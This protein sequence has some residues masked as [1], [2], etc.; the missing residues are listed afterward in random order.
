MSNNQNLRE[1]RRVPVSVAA[2]GELSLKGEGLD[3]RP[4]RKSSARSISF[5]NRSAVPLHGQL[6]YLRVIQIRTVRRVSIEDVAT[7]G[8]EWDRSEGLR[9]AAVWRKSFVVI[10]RRSSEAGPLIIKVRITTRHHHADSRHH[11]ETTTV[12]TSYEE[13]TCDSA[14]LDRVTRESKSN[15][16]H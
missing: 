14:S 11:A 13:M 3:G 9:R 12:L 2:V 8:H 15:H 4:M 7:R 16:P 10:G 6:H 5:P 1:L